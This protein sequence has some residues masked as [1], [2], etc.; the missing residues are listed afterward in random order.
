MKHSQQDCQFVDLE[1][2]EEDSE[3]DEEDENQDSM[4]P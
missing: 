3:D 4:S 1:A 2:R